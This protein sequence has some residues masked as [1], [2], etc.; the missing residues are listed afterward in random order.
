MGSIAAPTPERSPRARP[1]G[2]TCT[3]GARRHR[4][5]LAR[6]LG[7]QYILFG[8]WLAARHTVAYDKLPDVFVAFDVFD[9]QQGLFVSK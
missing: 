5:D 7:T 3:L 1:W 4:G 8:E 2:H 6:V 9:K